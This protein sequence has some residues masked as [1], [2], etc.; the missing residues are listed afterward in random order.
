MK[1]RFESLGSNTVLLSKGQILF[2][3]QYF[4]KHLLGIF[5]VYWEFDTITN[6]KKLNSDELS[7]FELCNLKKIANIFKN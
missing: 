5:Q 4:P 6:L 3:L 7:A 1:L 2:L